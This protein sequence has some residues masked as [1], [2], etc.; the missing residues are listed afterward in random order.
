MEASDNKLFANSLHGKLASS[1]LYNL[2]Q[3]SLN[4]HEPYVK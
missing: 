2:T 3:T 4:G 1:V